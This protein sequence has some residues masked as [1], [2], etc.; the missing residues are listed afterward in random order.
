M[1]HPFLMVLCAGLLAWPL[2]WAQPEQALPSPTVQRIMQSVVSVQT[3]SDEQANTARTLGQQRLGSGVVIAPDTVL[4]I[5]YLLLE[6]ETVDLIDHQGRRI[7]GQVRAVDNTSGLGLIRALVP[8]R[9]EAVPLGD[10]DALPTPGKLWTLGQRESELTALELVSRRPFAA[11]WEY[12]LEAPLMTL[13]AVNNWSG[14]GLFDQRG[15]LVGIGS[16]LVQDV[17]GDQVPLPGNLYVP[18]NLIKDPLPELLRQGKS[19]GPAPS[20]LGISSQALPGGGLSVLRV[21]PNSPAA[22]SGIMVGD[23]L[24]A[25]QG[26]A[27]DNLPDFYR[28]LRAV[29]PAGSTLTLSIR[30]E[31]QVRQ[32]EL[33]TADRNQ[34]LKRPSSI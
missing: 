33:V 9:L 6:A 11:V 20:W 31:G 23:T 13:P 24:L 25:L 4:T 28:R 18:V 2:A 34:S 12:W 16:L 15:R 29:G 8:L 5:G 32:I 22:Q 21:S 14:A 26:Q 19:L 3:R 30:R 17:F 1:N 10:S 7:P 27:L